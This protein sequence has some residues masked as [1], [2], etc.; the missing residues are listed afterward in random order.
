MSFNSYSTGTGGIVGDLVGRGK[1]ATSGRDEK[2]KGIDLPR[3]GRTEV[4]V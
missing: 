4:K 2:E 3:G 1:E